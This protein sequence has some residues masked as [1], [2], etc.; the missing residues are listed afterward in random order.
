MSLDC[1]GKQRS[2]RFCSEC[3]K[4]LA[5]GPLWDLLRSCRATEKGLR[6]RAE[7]ERRQGER[8]GDERYI[9]WSDKNVRNADEWK[10]RGD[11][12]LELLDRPTDPM[13]R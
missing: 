13:G 1:C 6:T 2:G 3:G 9:K 5:N 7:T 12:L 10:A 8:E 11:A 4:P